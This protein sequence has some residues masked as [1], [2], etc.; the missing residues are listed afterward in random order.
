MRFF[1]E[2]KRHIE[3]RLERLRDRKHRIDAHQAVDGGELLADR[4]DRAALHQNDEVVLGLGALAQEDIAA[5][6]SALK[7]IVAGT[8]GTCA[9]CGGAIGRGRLRA[10]P[11]TSMCHDC[12]DWVARAAHAS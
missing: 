8:Y 12:A 9:A 1:E 7:R 11:A 5:L 2:Q 10:L 4:L 6:E 3:L